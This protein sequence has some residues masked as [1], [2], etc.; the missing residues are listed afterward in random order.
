MIRCQCGKVVFD[1]VVL[2]IRVGQF[3]KG[4]MNLKCTQCR[5]WLNGLP[6]G[7]LTGE[8]N[9]D[10]DFSKANKEVHYHVAQS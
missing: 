5:A 10:I 3:S 9:D 1:G 7:L 6:V 8:I 2:K 4:F